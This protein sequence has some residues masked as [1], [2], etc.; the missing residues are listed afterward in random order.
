[1]TPVVSFYDINHTNLEVSKNYVFLSRI[2]LTQ[3]PA[4]GIGKA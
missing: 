4:M 3:V 1:M 2:D